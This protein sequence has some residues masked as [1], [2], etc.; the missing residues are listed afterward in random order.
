VSADTDA[1]RRAAA[2]MRDSDDVTVQL[3][4]L[5][6]RLAARAEMVMSTVGSPILGAAVVGSNVVG[7][8]EAVAFA[9]AYL[10]EEDPT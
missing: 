1:L 10:G 3:A 8:V 2:R 5:L 9:R 6:E 7:F 4:P